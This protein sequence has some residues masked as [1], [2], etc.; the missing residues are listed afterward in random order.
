MEAI[1]SSRGLTAV[2]Y[3]LVAL[4][5]TLLLS[6]YLL[7]FAISSQFDGPKTCR[8]NAQSEYSPPRG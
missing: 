4:P 6:V 1:K 5:A 2:E 7:G 8:V 3:V